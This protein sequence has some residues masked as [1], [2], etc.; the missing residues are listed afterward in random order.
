M[1]EH[2]AWR[3]LI[4][5]TLSGEIRADVAYTGDFT[6]E[7]TLCEKGSLAVSVY[8]DGPNAQVDL[9]TY[10]RPG[11]YSWILVYGTVIV[12]AGPVW[13]YQFNDADRTLQVTCGGMF[14]LFSR[15]V[16][17]N[18]AGSA[19]DPVKA[20]VNESEDLAY[21]GLSL[22]GI[23]SRL[24]SDNLAQLDYGMPSIHVPEPEAGEAERNYP[25]YNLKMLAD[26]MTD[27]AGVIGGPEFDF[28]PEFTEHGTHVRWNLKIGNPLL[29]DQESTNVWDYGTEGAPIG[30]IDVDVDGS[31]SPITR[32]WVKG[33]GTER[34][35]KTGFAE[36]LSR[37]HEGYPGTDFVDGDH[38]SV[39][40]QQTLEDYAD[41]DLELLSAA[42]EAWTCEVR[43]AGPGAVEYAPALSNWQLGEAPLFAIANHPWLPDGSYR[44]RVLGY[45][46]ASDSS[47]SLKLAE[48]PETVL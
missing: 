30:T 11:K 26:N 21:T 19:D 27:L 16:T 14:S 6:F 44:R 41:K 10:T 28:A 32:V 48:T 34:D 46:N 9:H 17:R 37:V 22:R 8:V 15:R 18:P 24:V 13:S 35:L 5:E 2:D 33:D 43:I 39:T 45:S 7:R 3:V 38:T 40:E 29:G 47:V 20:I 25:A 1:P 4:A 36:D 23:M 31:D 12:Q 42:T